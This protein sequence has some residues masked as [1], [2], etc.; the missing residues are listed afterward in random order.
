[1]SF[2]TACCA[3]ACA[4]A[5]TAGPDPLSDDL[6]PPKVGIVMIWQRP[7]PDF[8]VQQ[9]RREVDQIF[10]PSGLALRWEDSRRSL[11]GIYDRVVVV[12][13]RGKCSWERVRDFRAEDAL[14]GAQL[15]WTFLTDGEVVPHSV[16]DCDQVARTL[17][18]APSRMFERHPVPS[19]F[20]RLTA[21]VLAH[22]MLH[23]L[24]RSEGHDL[25]GLSRPSLRVEEL[26]LAM[27]LRPEQVAGL[28]RIG[29]QA[30]SPLAKG[31]ETN[32]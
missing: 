13:M 24:F 9:I 19:L 6:Q 16:V 31:A 22:E 7:T 2:R 15:G 20:T 5:A 29:R 8:V 28:R 10:R 3:L 32:R 4:A 17:A 25:A 18:S 23:V 30:G 12:E 21:R 11:R 14:N 26:P 27:K 1:M